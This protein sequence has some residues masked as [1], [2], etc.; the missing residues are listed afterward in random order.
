MRLC[1]VANHV[2]LLASTSAG[3]FPYWGYFLLA[4]IDRVS[5]QA[6]MEEAEA[7]PKQRSERSK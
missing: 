1:L 6:E 5:W 4:E 3:Y 7:L 2:G